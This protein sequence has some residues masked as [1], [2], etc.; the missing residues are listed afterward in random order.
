MEV[1]RYRLSILILVILVV[2]YFRNGVYAESGE[3]PTLHLLALVPLRETAG[4]PS[5]PPHNRGEDMIAAAEL[6]VNKI[7]L[8]DDI[9]PHYRL[10]LVPT[11]AELC[12]QNLAADALGNFVRHVTGG[13]L[14][15]VGVVGLVCSTVTQAVSP[16]AGR[17]EIDLLQISAGA[18]SPV[19]TSE[20]EYPRLYRMM[21]SSAVYNDAVLELMASLQWKRI[22]VVQDTKLI[23]HKTT[24]DN[25][26]TKVESSAELEVV[27]LRD[28]TPTF[29]TSPVQSLLPAR[30]KIIYASVTASEA[31]ELLCASYQSN[32]HW[33]EFVWLF[34]DL[35][36]EDLKES[37][38]NCSRE[39]ML[40]AVEGVFLLQYRLEP[41]PNTILVSG[42]TYQEYLMELQTYDMQGTQENQYANALHD[43]IWAFA[44]G[45]SNLTLEELH[46]TTLVEQNLKTVHFTGALGEISFREREVVNDVDIFHVRNGELVHTGNYNPRS[47]N[48]TILLSPEI[49]PSDDFETNV[50]ILNRAFIVVT[51][52]IVGALLVFTTFVL[53]LFIY[54]WNKP[55][56]K[57]SSPILSI[58]IFAGCYMIYV[59]CLIAG[60]NDIN[61]TILGCMCLAQVWFNAIGVQLVYSALFVRMLRI[62]RIFFK[63]FSKPGK[64]WSDQALLALSFI[65]TLITILVMILWTVVDPIV[66]GYT[67]VFEMGYDPPQ[68][69]VHVSCMGDH[70]I[71]WLLV[72]LC[73]LDGVTILGVV[74]LATLTRKVHLDC[75]K[76]TN[77]VNKFVFSTVICLCIWLPYTVV[78]TNVLFIPE[79]AQVFTI[80]PYLVITFLCIRFLF[81]PKIQSARHE[82]QKS[83]RKKRERKNNQVILITHRKIVT[84]L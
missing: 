17:P 50:V 30:A 70:L 56:I 39:T 84:G 82:R 65:P 68:H 44:L 11:N 9:L 33:P 6:A 32:L 14:N 27:L 81:V 47:G 20:E 13:D 55:S 8:R 26:L 79:A 42:Q 45:L 34:H 37:T 67:A 31:R 61:P 46:T 1:L 2:S 38:G 74:I 73:V 77:Q 41:N 71:E 64:I 15:I 36:V 66:T 72:V 10:E 21:S 62:Y 58:L 12:G 53:V 5:Q 16:L 75:F 49:I 43:S 63:V 24:A 51:Y 76:D 59:G 78:F 35:S 60:A 54:Y 18:T 69:A 80:L 40:R 48:L 28:V 57:A 29:P 22:G 83:Q 23:Q 25:F 3:I 52:T 7:N 19:F 4:L